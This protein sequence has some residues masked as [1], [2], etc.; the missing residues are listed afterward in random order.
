MWS[1]L[2]VPIT[3][4]ISLSIVIIRLIL[5]FFSLAQSEHI[6]ILLII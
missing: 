3:K 4:L 5:S 1:Q 6:K 2:K